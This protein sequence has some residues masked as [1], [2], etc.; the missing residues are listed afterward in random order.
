MSRACASRCPNGRCCDG[1][2]LAPR[3]PARGGD[4]AALPGAENDARRRAGLRRHPRGADGRGSIDRPVFKVFVRGMVRAAFAPRPARDLRRPR[5][6]PQRGGPP[7]DRS[8]RPQPPSPACLLAELQP[9]RAGL[10]NAEDPLRWTEARTRQAGRG[11]HDSTAATRRLRR[12]QPDPLLRLWPT[13][14]PPF[15]E[16][17]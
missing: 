13:A 8:Q 3:D 16:L 11:H 4:G 10:H 2:S 5:R 6:P 7:P 17:L 12:L 1:V 14:I 15:L 9:D